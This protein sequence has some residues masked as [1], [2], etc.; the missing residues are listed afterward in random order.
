M[1]VAASRLIDC[2]YDGI[3]VSSTPISFTRVVKADCNQTILQQFR[4]GYTLEQIADEFDISVQRV[5][6]I[7]RWWGS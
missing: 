5:H 7:I 1:G 6:E 2:F 4:D 3:P